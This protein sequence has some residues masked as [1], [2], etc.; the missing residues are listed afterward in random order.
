MTIM[1]KI[2]S[3]ALL[4]TIISFIL[5]RLTTTHNNAIALPK[6]LMAVQETSAQQLG[7]REDNLGIDIGSQLSDFTVITYDGQATTLYNLLQNQTNF[8]IFY[9]GGWCPYCNYHVK[10][11]TE[12]YHLF[13]KENIQVILI[14]ADDADGEILLKN[15][16]HIPFPL[17]TDPLLTAY[18]AFNVTLQFSELEALMAK[19]LYDLNL[20]NWSKQPHHKVA[21]PAYFLL[22]QQGIVKWEHV[23]QDYTVR[24][25][26]K[27]LL[28]V[29]K[30]FQT[31]ITK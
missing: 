21:V 24:P 25:S 18:E 6:K 11:L 20:E 30:H 27:Q 8:I 1:K 23:A 16:Y 28:S 31:Q 5:F 22:D 13:E 15:T 2:F 14:S 4:F 26:P 9:R 10:Q 12:S 7:T 19:I 29:A 3:I 17:I